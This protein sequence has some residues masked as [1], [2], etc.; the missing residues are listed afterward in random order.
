MHQ[1]MSSQ[2][3]RSVILGMHTQQLS[4]TEV[5]YDLLIYRQKKN[6]LT[7]QIVNVLPN[8][9]MTANQWLLSSDCTDMIEKKTNTTKYG[10]LSSCLSTLAIR[11]KLRSHL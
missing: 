7:I 10:P 5:F 3:L 11:N 9:H 2:T 1:K 6:K 8:F 4:E